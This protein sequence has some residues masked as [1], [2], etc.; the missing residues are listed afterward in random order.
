MAK[1]LLLT[2]LGAV[3]L[4]SSASRASI[5]LSRDSNS[6]SESSFTSTKDDQWEL[7]TDDIV[8]QDAVDTVDDLADDKEIENELTDEEKA[9]GNHIEFP[10]DQMDDEELKLYLALEEQIF[11]GQADEHVAFQLLK[12]KQS[13]YTK[14]GDRLRRKRIAPLLA[15]AAIIAARGLARR[16]ART[17]ITRSG[18][19]VT[20]HYNGRGTYSDAMRDFNRMRPTNVRSFSGRISGRTGTMGPHRVTVRDGSSG[21][22]S[23]PTMEIRSHGGDLVRKFRYNP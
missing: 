6:V 14:G 3:L 5:L 20:R 15:R 22:N 4:L 11:H 2:L 21:P 23:R 17:G 9:V 1:L 12:E 19:R 10:L 18:S 13:L 16:F 8:D 7:V